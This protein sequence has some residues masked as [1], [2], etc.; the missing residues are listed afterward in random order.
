MSFVLKS[1]FNSDN[2]HDKYQT[3]NIL[4]KYWNFHH[5]T[6]TT[7]TSVYNLLLSKNDKIYFNTHFNNK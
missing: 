2:P 4:L 5:K 3:N 6:M 1:R 7:Y